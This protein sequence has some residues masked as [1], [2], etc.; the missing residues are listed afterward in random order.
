MVLLLPAI[1][2]AAPHI[3]C[4]QRPTTA[5]DLAQEYEH[6]AQEFDGWPGFD[7]LTAP[8][9]IYDGSDTYLFWHPAPPEGFVE[10]G[11]SSPP[12]HV[13]QGRH[14]A[15]TANSSA[16]IGGVL[17]ATLLADPDDRTGTREE[18]ARVALH[19]TFHVYQRD[20]HPGWQP[21]EVDLFTYP[22]EREDLL[23]L[24]RLETIAL[25]RAM[26]GADD[27]EASCWARLALQFRR[28]RYSELEDPFAVYE[29]KAELT[30]GLATYVQYAGEEDQTLLPKV[31]SFPPDEVR[32]RAYTS[33]YVLAVL[34]DRFDPQWKGTVGAHDTPW[35]DS[36]L[37]EA[38]G[39]GKVC[40]L[41]NEVTSE[42][43]R[44]ARD[45]IKDLLSRR[46]Q[47]KTQFESRSGSRVVIETGSEPLWP[48]EFDPVNVTNV[49]GGVLHTRFLRLGNSSGSLE[50]INGQALTEGPGPHPLFNGVHR[51]TLTGLTELEIDVTADSV[52]VKNSE[53]A[54]N[55]RGAS[56]D[57]EDDTLILRLGDPE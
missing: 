31:E 6:L 51:V 50:V 14:P 45:A 39:E 20:N 41:Q 38:L 34:L 28:A 52:T 46:S 10:V 24:R 2:L 9:A 49:E 23:Y 56:A 21:N 11:N 15:V 29:R 37:T 55:F 33:G 36:L 4:Q 3:A 22:A 7:P 13:Y 57:Q 17:S 54:L 5:Q 47:L 35:L 42:A 8:L 53:V 44:A 43:E 18:I 30:E 19:E 48:Q 32:Q 27:R 40:F 25:E 26:T 16:E 12:S 1:L